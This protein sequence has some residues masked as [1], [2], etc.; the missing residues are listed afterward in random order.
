MPGEAEALG[1]P[2][3]FGRV[4]GEMMRFRLL[5]ALVLVLLAGGRVARGEDALREGER[6]VEVFERYPGAVPVDADGVETVWCVRIVDAED[7]RPIPGAL[8]SVP[9]HPGGGVPDAELHWLCQGIADWDGWVRLPRAAFEG[10]MDYSFAD[11]P[12][13]AANEYCEPWDERCALARGV[14][15]P[16]VLLDYVGR[17]VPHARLALNLGCGHVPDQRSVVTDAEGRAVL[18]DVLPSRHEDVWVEAPHCHRGTTSL[19][20]TWRAGDPPV[21]IDAVPG[22]EVS[23]TVQRADG[24]PVHHALVGAK[25]RHRP[26]TTTDREGRFH[27]FGVGAWSQI[28]VHAPPDLGIEGTSFVAP[29]EGVG[30]V[31]VLDA[32]PATLPVLV[33]CVD[34][35]GEAARDVH[36]ALVRA[37]DGLVIVGRTNHVGE[38]VLDAPPGAYRVL[39]DGE[40]GTWGTAEAALEV[41]EDGWTTVEVHVPRSPTVLVDASRVVGCRVGLTTPYAF[42]LLS[43]DGEDRS[44][45][46]V[47]VPGSGPARFRI[48]AREDGELLV[49]YVDVPEPGGAV[50]LEWLPATRVTARLVGPDGAPVRGVLVL[51]RERWQ[52]EEVLVPEEIASADPSPWAESRLVG[53]VSWAA[54]P[55]EGG[56]A[57]ATGDVRLPD[58]G[59]TVDLG[60]VRLSAWAPPDVRVGLPADLVEAGDA[61]LVVRIPGV[62]GEF[63]AEILEDGS[64]DPE[65][66][67]DWPALV[68]GTR[69]EVEM[70]GDVPMLPIRYVATGPPP[71]RIAWPAA[72]LA[73]TARDEV[74]EALEDAVV[75]VDGRAL[76]EA[77]RDGTPILV[78]GVPAGWHDVIVTGR[79]HVGKR[80]RL[81][82]EDGEARS[83]DVALTRRT[84]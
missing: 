39:A 17:P 47:P 28:E 31:V 55:V 49:S 12:G 48:S 41:A 80:Y 72:T 70:Y 43:F 40:L 66:T 24:A 33:R 1:A 32:H 11:A 20:R 44:A 36:V 73:I 77:W 50:R 27:L 78:R 34:P 69:A 51:A 42:R 23:G 7:G 22:I 62:E 30:R 8:V 37:A 46:P 76:G 4:Q 10:W 56:L 79:D 9:A 59:G 54:L 5:F 75:L 29:P 81:R 45:V 83:L 21:A 61:G 82:I 2:S 63:A 53:T 71:W 19:R 58:Q 16:V 26:W 14:D 38:V 60:T 84:D 67:R 35:E 3:A 15:V 57:P 52:G 6:V 68:A 25:D 64:L 74:G 13:Y 65:D 18:R